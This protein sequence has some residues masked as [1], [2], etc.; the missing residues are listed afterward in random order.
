MAG[1]IIDLSKPNTKLLGII[2][3]TKNGSTH[4]LKV[5]NSFWTAIYPTE[6]QI[7]NHL[8]KSGIKDIHNSTVSFTF[9]S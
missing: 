2:T 5:Y 3:Y 9:T 4:E 7:K 6:N 1:F 8:N